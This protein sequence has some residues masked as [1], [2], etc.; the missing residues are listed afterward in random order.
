MNKKVN[1]KRLS[2]ILIISYL[3]IGIA[4]YFI[5]GEQFYITKSNDNLV[6][7]VEN[8]TIGPVMS[9]TKIEQDFKVQYYAIDGIKIKTDTNEKETKG[10][11]S[12]SLM[13]KDSNIVLFQEKID[14][15]K[16][17]G[18]SDVYLNTNKKTLDVKNKNLALI[19]TSDIE[20]ENEAPVIYTGNGIGNLPMYIDGKLTDKS[21]LISM[22]CFDKSWFGP[23]Y[24]YIFLGGLII[25]SWYL[26]NINIKQKNETDS[27][28]LNVINVYMK[29]KF[30]LSQLIQRDFKTKYKR[31]VLGVLWSFFNPL[32]TM[33][34]QYIVFST[35]FK[36]D[37]PNF[38]VYL[39]IG[40][41]MFNFFSEACGMGLMA[42]LGNASLITKVYVPKYIY[43]V[44]RVFSSV[45]NLLLSLIPLAI[46]II[47]TQ[48]QI[49]F[50]VLLIIFGIL[51]TIV[52]CIGMALI[53]STAMVFFR[54]TQFLW[55][56][57]SLL[58]MYLTPLFYPES[59]VPD[60]FKFIL[61]LNP[62]YH[63]IRFVRICILDGVSPE[64]IAYLICIVFSVGT[65]LI[66]AWVFK[67]NQD[68]FVL[69]I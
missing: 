29:Y 47:V 30:L 64:P 35:I 57:V 23:N 49:K 41:V 4:F 59:I 48:T 46:V 1:L 50:S 25:L 28:G 45:I 65:F 6:Y 36:S 67:K 16:F 42:I 40:V 26:I 43:P 27:Y 55:N 5:G 17:N 20:N 39:L 19:I 31:S 33:A 61:Q 18:K 68:K 3:I 2:F 15:S 38:P 21:L 32:L 37:I 12:V 52:F 58:W 44:S 10:N 53:L 60:K 62:M 51:C 54:D 63:F 8:S 22:E 7:D 34:V 24:W 14:V 11:L 56:V 13:D 9:S 66:G 69:N